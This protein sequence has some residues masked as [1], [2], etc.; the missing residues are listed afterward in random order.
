MGMMY[1]PCQGLEGGTYFQMFL[2]TVLVFVK[3]RGI[4]YSTLNVIRFLFW[5]STYTF[6]L[7]KQ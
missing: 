4:I 7:H 3:K 5:V 6:T 1:Q 2:H